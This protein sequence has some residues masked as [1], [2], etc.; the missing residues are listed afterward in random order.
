MIAPG[1]LEVQRSGASLASLSLARYGWM[2]INEMVLPV[3]IT[4][5]VLLVWDTL[6]RRPDPV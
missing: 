6:A 1:H 5:A 3:V 4:A 2:A